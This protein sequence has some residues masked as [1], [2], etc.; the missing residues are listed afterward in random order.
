MP[1]YKKGPPFLNRPPF[2]RGPPFR[3]APETCTLAGMDEPPESLITAMAKASEVWKRHHAAE[4][5]SA[6]KLAVLVREG[7]RCGM[8]E[9]GLAA[10]AGVTRKTV[11]KWLGKAAP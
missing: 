10:A 11:R 6:A 5:E 9:W 3:T 7:R 4:R 2:E 8:T 1:P